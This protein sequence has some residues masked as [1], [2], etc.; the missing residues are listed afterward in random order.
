MERSH[1]ITETDEQITFSWEGLTIQS[2]GSSGGSLK[3]KLGLA[4]GEAVKKPPKVILNKGEGFKTPF[5]VLIGD[6]V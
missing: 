4:K 2:K 5:A 1:S 6:A 3:Q